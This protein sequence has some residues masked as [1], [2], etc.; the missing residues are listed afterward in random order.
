MDDIEFLGSCMDFTFRAARRPFAG[1]RRPLPRGEDQPLPAALIRCDDQAI[2]ILIDNLSLAEEHIK[3]LLLQ[4]LRANAL[5]A[6]RI[7]QLGSQ[8]V[9]AL[10]ARVGQFD[11][12]LLHVA[13]VDLQ[14]LALSDGTQKD[15]GPR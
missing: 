4:H 9:H 2:R 14:P 12:A 11:Q 13:R 3:R 7:L 10:A 8:L 15:A 5:D 6:A 1:T